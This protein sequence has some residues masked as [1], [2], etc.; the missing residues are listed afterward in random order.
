MTTIF[1]IVG[2]PIAQVRSPEV[3]NTLF[4]DR[5]IDAVM[6]PLL[7]TPGHFESA[8]E[9]LRRIGNLGGLV[10]TVPHKFAA[11]RLL[12][13]ASHRVAIT[14]AANAIRPTDT[15]WAGDLYDGEG[16]AIGVEANHGSVAGKRCA[17]VGAGGAGTAIALSLIDRG[18]AGIRLWDVDTQR[19]YTLRNRLAAFTSIPVI[20]DQPSQL[21]DIAINASSAGMSASDRL[22][23]EPASLRRGT[24][25]CE[26]I[27]K[28]PRTPL[29]IEAE[30]LG[31]PTQEG[32]HMLDH[33]VNA[34]WDFFRLSPA[35]GRDI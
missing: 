20:V 3:F 35:G 22:P 2:D 8:V 29:L 26:A 7:V 30:K 4:R 28:P 5:G 1:G 31:H 14:G 6:V 32:R 23:F 12:S 24:L 33:Q 11:A 25:V 17:I 9:G 13:E 15:G 18:V 19:A 10:I 16:F 27:M 21:D 34:I